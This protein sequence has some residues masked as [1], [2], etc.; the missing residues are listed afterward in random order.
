MSIADLKESLRQTVRERR[1]QITPDQVTASA[2][3]LVENFRKHCNV[4]PGLTVSAYWPSKFEIDIKPL[5]KDLLKGGNPICLPVVIGKEKPLIFRRFA[6][7]D[8]LVRG[9]GAWVPDD[10]MTEAVPDFL[11]VPLIAFDRNG[12]RLGQ[13]AGY[14][15]RTLEQLRA[16]KPVRA[17]GI[18]YAL[19]EVAEVPRDQYDQKLDGILTEAA[20]HPQE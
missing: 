9:N 12:G 20:F 2:R 5:I 10:T 6:W 16:V 4:A 1:R 11:L 18:A 14:Y 7:G 15:D 13:G 8:E 19:Q 3:A 17:I